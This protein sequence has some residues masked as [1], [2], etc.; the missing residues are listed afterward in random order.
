MK[1][2][3]GSTLV[4]LLFITSALLI[5]LAHIGKNALQFALI[6]RLKAQQSQRDYALKSLAL[7]AAR[8]YKERYG[9]YDEKNS[10]RTIAD[11]V[12]I[13]NWPGGDGALYTGMFQVTSTAAHNVQMCVQITDHNNHIRRVSYQLQTTKN[14]C[15]LHGWTL[16]A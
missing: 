12:Y 4:I 8:W 7:Y 15:S 5:G 3:A 9:I 2:S 14:G 1:N 11:M 6:S 10:A 13:D 16:E